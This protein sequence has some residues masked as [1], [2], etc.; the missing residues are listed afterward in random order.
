MSNDTVKKKRNDNIDNKKGVVLPRPILNN[1]YDFEVLRSDIISI[2]ANQKYK[3]IVTYESS[4]GVT[5]IIPTITLP[6]KKGFMKTAQKDDLY[7]LSP[8]IDLEH[9]VCEIELLSQLGCIDISYHCETI[10]YRNKSFWAS[11]KLLRGLGMKKE[12]I[13]TS[14]VRYSCTDIDSGLFD[15]FVFTIE[16]FIV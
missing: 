8:A 2:V 11:S 5:P 15:R 7:M 16:W 13:S 14:K 4:E 6:S 1:E 9:S 12:F 3:L 10:D